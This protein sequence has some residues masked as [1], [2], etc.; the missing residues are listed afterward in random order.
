[1]VQSPEKTSIS[2]PITVSISADT[3]RIRITRQTDPGFTVEICAQPKD[4]NGHRDLYAH[5]LCLLVENGVV[6]GHC[7]NTCQPTLHMN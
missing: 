5:L 2:F 6:E 3:S 1:M 4:P 7:T